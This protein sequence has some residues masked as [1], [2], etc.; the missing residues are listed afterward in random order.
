MDDE[1]K[2]IALLD[3]DEDTPRPSTKTIFRMDEEVWRA[4]VAKGAHAREAQIEKVNLDIMTR[5]QTPQRQGQDPESKRGLEREVKTKMSDTIVA[6]TF[7]HTKL[8][9]LWF[10]KIPMFEISV[11]SLKGL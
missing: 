4:K 9:L 11:H 10:M 8:I 1:D 5:A 3:L 7:L 2:I 6:G